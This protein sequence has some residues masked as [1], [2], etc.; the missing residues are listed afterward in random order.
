M[1]CPSREGRHLT[2]YMI[3]VHINHADVSKLRIVDL[4]AI[5]TTCINPQLAY[6]VRRGPPRFLRT[7]TRTAVDMGP[8]ADA[9]SIDPWDP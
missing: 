4:H 2:R 5:H 6:R 3:R 9:E 1:R 7:G 8:K